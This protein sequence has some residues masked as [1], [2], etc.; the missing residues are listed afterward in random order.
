M[1][2]RG[3]DIILGGNADYL[4]RNEMR[5]DGMEEEMIENAVSHAAT[6]DPE[7]IAA[8]KKYAELVEKHKK[9]HGCGA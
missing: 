2:G 8:R 7:I 6:K 1:A 5:A 9:G 3:T 4:A